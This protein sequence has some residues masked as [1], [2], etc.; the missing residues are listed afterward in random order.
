MPFG[1]RGNGL[2][3]SVNQPIAVAPAEGELRE[4]R[5][6]YTAWHLTANMQEMEGWVLHGDQP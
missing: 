1:P 2:P 6:L 3:L 5:G 4:E